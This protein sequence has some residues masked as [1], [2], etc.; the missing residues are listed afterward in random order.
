MVAFLT[1]ISTLQIIFNESSDDYFTRKDNI[2]F[3]KTV[4]VSSKK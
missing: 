2:V 4:L 1:V 3:Q